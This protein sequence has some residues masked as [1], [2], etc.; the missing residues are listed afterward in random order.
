MVELMRHK[1]PTV[2]AVTGID[3]SQ[4]EVFFLHHKNKTHLVVKRSSFEGV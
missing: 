1:G 2:L 4:N 3:F